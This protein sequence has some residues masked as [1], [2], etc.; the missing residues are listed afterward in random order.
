ME[1]HGLGGHELDA[2]AL[3]GS[4]N[5]EGLVQACGDGLFAKDVL[6]AFGRRD[7][8][9]GVEVVRR[10][11]VNGVDVVAVED[12]GKVGIGLAAKLEAELAGGGFVWV[13]YGGQLELR[14]SQN[15]RKMA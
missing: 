15:G 8:L 5:G 7:C 10:A 14:Q 9:G 3:D 2:S 11:N 4:A 12:G 1:A 6:A 13:N